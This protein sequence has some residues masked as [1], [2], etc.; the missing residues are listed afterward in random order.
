MQAVIS[1][2]SHIRRGF[3]VE[4]D[5]FYSRLALYHKDFPFL[6]NLYHA[7]SHIAISVF[8][9]SERLLCRITER[10][11]YA[12]TFS[13]IDLSAL[14]KVFLVRG[15][16]RLGNSLAR[17]KVTADLKVLCFTGSY[18]FSVHVFWL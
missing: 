7:L 11:A 1:F 8:E 3:A 16:V 5:F 12:K 13:T 18:V 9:I 15:P 14:T 6:I 4:F 10:S 17:N 2:S